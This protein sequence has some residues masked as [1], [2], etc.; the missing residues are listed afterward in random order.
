MEN[1]Q[2]TALK[3][4]K[5]KILLENQVQELIEK[6]Q[7]LDKEAWAVSSQKQ[8]IKYRLEHLRKQPEDYFK[9]YAKELLIDS[10]QS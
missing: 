3:I 4:S 8:A 9:A 6:E 2:I 5:E 10:K 7:F 1:D